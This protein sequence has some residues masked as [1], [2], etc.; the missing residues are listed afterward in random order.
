MGTGSYLPEKVVTNADLEKL[1]DTTDQ[2]IRERTGICERRV[3]RDDE[4]SCDMAEPA[5][6][7]ALESAAISPDE[8][9]LLI[10]GAHGL[11]HF[12]S[13]RITNPTTI[14]RRTIQ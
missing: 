5:A 3:A 8:I 12:T 14:R 10:V 9:G 4:T 6:Q 13:A 1:L 2:W 11:A 7:R